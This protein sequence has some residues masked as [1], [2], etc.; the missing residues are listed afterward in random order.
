M[1]NTPHSLRLV[2]TGSRHGRHDVA[3]ALDAWMARHGAPLL[4]VVGDQ[5]GVDTQAKAWAEQ[6]GFPFVQE[7]VRKGQPWPH[8]FHDRNQ[9]M[10]DHAQ[11]GDHLLAFPLEDSRGTWHCFGRGKARGLVCADV[12][13]WWF[14]KYLPAKNE[15]RTR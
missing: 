10:V 2:I 13:R 1:T 5:R 15:N 14:E 8:C 7:R 11:P 4:V 12:N 3:L 9:R 6:H